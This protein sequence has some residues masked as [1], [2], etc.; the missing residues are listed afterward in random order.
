MEL[1]AF[2]TVITNIAIVIFG[3]IILS[4]KPTAKYF[5]L[6]YIFSASS[7]AI[8]S[9]LLLKNQFKKVIS[10]FQFDLAKKIMSAAW[11]IALLY[12]INI[13]MLDID[14]VM[15]GFF[16]TSQEVGLYSAGQRIIQI[17]YTIPS[18]ISM[19]FFPA[20]SRFAHANENIKTKSIMEKSLSAVM[21]IG[22]PLVVGGI[23]LGK[24][25]ISLLYGPEYSLSV[26][27]FKILL[28]NIIFV[29]PSYLISNYI[30]AYN[31]QKKIG[32][33]LMVGSACNILLNFFLIP[34]YG[35]IGAATA[36]I[37][38][39]AIYQ[40]LVFGMAKK[41]NNFHIICYLKKIFFSAIIMGILAY[42]ANLIGI[43]IIINILISGIIYF[44]TLYLLKEKI[45]EQIIEPGIKKII[46][47]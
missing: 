23:V 42:C 27:P 41:I 36:T 15:L 1:E 14:V 21:L 34:K 18:I 6:T 26:I 29:F 10:F 33:Y 3:I 19:S 47:H 9:I 43:N 2:V 12:I 13:F 44:L 39:Q 16:K 8:A 31:Q 37:I 38:S 7:G 40:S 35:T 4:M 24:E 17:F 30:L 32:P 5:V 45:I 46:R 22:I 20:I 28:I 25:I 11:P